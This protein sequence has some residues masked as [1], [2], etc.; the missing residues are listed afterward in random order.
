MI[1]PG[2]ESKQ[3]YVSREAAPAAGAPVALV[4]DSG[5]EVDLAAAQGRVLATYTIVCD[6][7]PSAS[8]IESRPF[9][10]VKAAWIEG[11]QKRDEGCRIEP[12]SVLLRS[13]WL[14]SLDEHREEWN[15]HVTEGTLYDLPEAYVERFWGVLF[16]DGVFDYH[17]TYVLGVAARAAPSAQFVLVQRTY[18]PDAVVSR[19]PTREGLELE[20]R[21]VRDPDVATAYVGRPLSR[22][23]EELRAIEKRFHVTYE[24]RSYGA[25]S[26]ARREKE[27]PGL[28]W[29]DHFAA[30]AAL[31]A[32]ADQERGARFFQDDDVLLFASAGND[33]STIDAPVDSYECPSSAVADGIVVVGAF[34]PAGVVSKFS[35]RGACVDVYAPGEEVQSWA[36]KGYRVPFGGTSAAAPLALGVAMQGLGVRGSPRERKASLLAQIRAQAGPRTD[37]LPLRWVPGDLLYPG[38]W[39][40]RAVTPTEGVYAMAWR[41][42][43]LR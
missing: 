6:E 28:P 30:W 17:G 5:F 42:F 12:G 24:N 4:I 10:E 7:R 34:G 20:T 18:A 1:G 13:A 38:T 35:N 39:G 11:Y 16:G 29:G 27:C 26:R 32:R 36:P 23:T 25:R 37:F 19:C 40:P 43:E 9:E 2:K 3:T 8:P 33:G 41:R 14:D 31:T 22:Y 15:E 21:L